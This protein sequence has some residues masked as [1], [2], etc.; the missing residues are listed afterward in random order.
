M[1][2]DPDRRSVLAGL[3]AFGLTAGCA[4][5]KLGLGASTPGIAITIDD[6]DLSDT[7]LLSGEDRDTAIRAALRRHRVNAGGFV[8]GKYVNDT[9]SPRVLAR[10]SKMA[11][12]SATIVFRMNISTGKTPTR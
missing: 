2:F 11:T 9:V 12:L 3:A 4:P 7:V 1:T 5:Q 6:F 8:A 10:W